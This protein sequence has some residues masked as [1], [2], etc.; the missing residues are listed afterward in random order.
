MTHDLSLHASVQEEASE[1]GTCLQ[2]NS[3]QHEA[4]LLTL[5]DVQQYVHYLMANTWPLE[6]T[7]KTTIEATT[8]MKSE[9]DHTTRR[10][11][12]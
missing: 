12:N 1:S 4:A 2:G 8:T 10:F 3:G 6:P 9:R 5:L 7:D 11:V